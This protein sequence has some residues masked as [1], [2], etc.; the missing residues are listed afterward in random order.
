MTTASP[1]SNEA[2]AD[3][4]VVT[5]GRRDYSAVRDVHELPN[6]IQLQMDSYR[7]FLERGLKQLF[8]EV[9]PIQ[10]FTGKRMELIFGGY[11]LGDPPYN[12]HECRQQDLTYS[13][14]LRVTVQLVVKDSGEIKEQE[15]F[16]GDFPLMTATGTFVINGA[17]RVVVSQLVRSPGVYFST[18]VDANTGRDLCSAKL[19]P[20]RGAWLEFESSARDVLS[21]KV[22][23]KRK[24]PVTTLLRAVD[25][26]PEIED[27]A[28]LGTDDRIRA[29]LSSVD[30]NERHQFVQATMAREPALVDGEERNKIW[31][32]LEVY[33]RLRPGDP[34]TAE[35]AQGLLASLFFNPR[36]YDLGRVG[37]HKLN[38]R[39][40]SLGGFLE[41]EE[42]T[43][44]QADLVA[45]VQQQIPHQQRPWPGRRY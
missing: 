10:D 40:Q 15:L 6:L 35:N 38:K 14:P 11:G 44:R 33:R 27:A 30:T 16:F 5:E 22:D 7:W 31:A 8:D 34:P 32:L 24:I 4:L 21:V 13:A 19:I 29:L 20:N 1:K 23:R 25:H 12:E 36:R 2:G 26:E 18:T 28:Q 43:L 39:L 45:I 9:S 37:R 42:S 41:T 3:R 17:E